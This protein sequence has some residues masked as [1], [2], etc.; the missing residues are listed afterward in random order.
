MQGKKITNTKKSTHTQD[1]NDLEQ[2]TLG[3][4]IAIARRYRQVDQQELARRIHTHR[5]QMSRYETGQHKIPALVLKKI[6]QEL[7]VSAD[8][9]LGLRVGWPPPGV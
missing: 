6:A 4:A 8:W 3:Q 9:L 7:N 1:N 5:V 2:K